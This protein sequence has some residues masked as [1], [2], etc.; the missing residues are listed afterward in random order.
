M[1][2]PTYDQPKV[3]E[4]IRFTQIDAGSSGR[5]RTFAK[6]PGRETIEAVSA[7]LVAINY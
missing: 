5:M 7:D 6:D 2:V 3:A 1:E 4:L